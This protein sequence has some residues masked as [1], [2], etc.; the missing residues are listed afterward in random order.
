MFPPMR[1]CARFASKDEIGIAARASADE[2]AG[3]R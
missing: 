3:D 1:G 2:G